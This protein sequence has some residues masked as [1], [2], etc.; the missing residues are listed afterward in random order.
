MKIKDLVGQIEHSLGRQ[1]HNYLFS[2][3]NDGLDEIAEKTRTNTQSSYTTLTGGGQR[4]VTLD[5]GNM[6]DV[7]RVE[8]QDSSGKYRLIGKLMGEIQIGDEA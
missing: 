2:L 1:S 3:M 6:I 5:L 7:F 4:W 8:V